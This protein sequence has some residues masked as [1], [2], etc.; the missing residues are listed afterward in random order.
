MLGTP[1]K[2]QQ[3]NCVLFV[4]L[5]FRIEQPHESTPLR[6]V[7]I[8][9]LLVLRFDCFACGLVTSLSLFLKVSFPV[10]GVRNTVKPNEQYVDY[11]NTRIFNF[12]G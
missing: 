6:P 12:C 7:S 2:Y 10:P 5:I 11:N 3:N 1:N 8:Y 4:A 9:Y